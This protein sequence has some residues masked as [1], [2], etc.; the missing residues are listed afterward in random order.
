MAYQPESAHFQSLFEPALRAYEKKAG[1]SLAQHPLAI[2]LQNCDSV[3]AITR[4]FQ[5]Q[6]R[7]FRNLR[8][9]DKIMKSIKTTVSILSKLSS[10]DSPADTFG[11]VHQQELVECHIF[12]CSS[13]RS[14]QQ[15][16]YKLVSLFYLTYVTFSSS[17]EDDLV[18]FQ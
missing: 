7:N 5:D 17:Y 18:T 10:A 4:I 6:A 3:E 16:R 1:V 14:H 12:D 15:K 9:S 2:K 8:G 13:R 11:L